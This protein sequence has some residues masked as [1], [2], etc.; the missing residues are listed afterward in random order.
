MNVGLAEN[1]I[2]VGGVDKHRSRVK[3]GRERGASGEDGTP[4]VFGGMGKEG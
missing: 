3:V 4:E 2:E 1:V